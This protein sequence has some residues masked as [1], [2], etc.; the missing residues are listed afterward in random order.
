MSIFYLVH[1]SQKLG[2]ALKIAIY[3]GWKDFQMKSHK[4][5]V[6]KDA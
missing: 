3:R 4:I 6:N 5:L 2:I 1:G